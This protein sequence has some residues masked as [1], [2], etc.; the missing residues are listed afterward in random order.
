MRRHTIKILLLIDNAA[1]EKLKAITVL[2]LMPNILI[3]Q[4][5]KNSQ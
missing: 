3:K 2:N 5:P 1:V 4:G